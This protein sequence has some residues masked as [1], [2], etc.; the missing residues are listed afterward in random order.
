M[1]LHYNSK[2]KTKNKQKTKTNKN[3][4]KQNNKNAQ[5]LV[6]TLLCY[7]YNRLSLS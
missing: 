6:C 4:T 1:S 5:E 7:T 3:K 2:K